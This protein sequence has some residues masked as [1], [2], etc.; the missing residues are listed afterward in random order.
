[1]EI[2]VFKC[3]SILQN[4]M[5]YAFYEAIEPNMPIAET[6]IILWLQGGPGCSSMNGN[7]YELG[8][9]RISSDLK[10]YQNDSPWNR[11]FGV[12]FIDSP[13]GSGYNIAEKDEDIPTDQNQVAEHLYT[14]LEEFYSSVPEFSNRL[15]FVAGESYAGK[16]VPALGHCILMKSK[17][18]TMENAELGSLGYGGSKLPFPLGGL[19]I[20]NGL[21]D[22]EIQVQTHAN[23]AYNFGLIE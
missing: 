22:P 9:W 15:L 19:L 13:V 11:K 6:P 18:N 23:V 8:P 14:A 21:T 3:E 1:M 12:L 16:Y 20:G 17:K 4:K 2:W 10:L 5:F 7:F